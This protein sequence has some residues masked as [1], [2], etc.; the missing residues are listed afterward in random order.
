MRFIDKLLGKKSSQ[1]PED[2]SEKERGKF[3]PDPELPIDDKFI[4]NFKE[5]G[6]K[7]LYCEDE[8]EVK[9]VFRDILDENNWKSEACCFNKKLRELF[10]GSGLTFTNNTSTSFCILDC[11]FLVAN[12]GAILLSS[13]QIGEKKLNELPENMVIYAYTSQLIGTIDEGM[14]R[15]KARKQTIPSNITTIKN[16]KQKGEKEG[17]FMSYG[18]VSRNLYLLL[19]EDL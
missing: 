17:H 14:R 8:E 10:S 7:F 11:E 12:D 18:L 5:N 6:G 13:N 19:Q 15:I 3:M 9:A 1:K 4:M 16:F 2:S